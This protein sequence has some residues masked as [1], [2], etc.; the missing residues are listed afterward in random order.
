MTTVA[1]AM[2]SPL[3][4]S[5]TTT[6]APLLKPGGTDPTGKLTSSAPMRGGA[7]G[8]PPPPPPPPHEESAK[9]SAPSNAT[10]SGRRYFA[11][12]IGGSSLVRMYYGDILVRQVIDFVSLNLE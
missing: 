10:E 3:E 12:S 4:L 1:V 5:R 7:G 8:S 6:D 9:A 11:R 2:L